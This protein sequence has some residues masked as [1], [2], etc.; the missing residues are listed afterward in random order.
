MNHIIANPKARKY[1]YGIVAAAIPLLVLGGF[2]TEDDVQ[3]WLTLAAAVL[4]FGSA[5]LAAPNTPDKSDKV[6]PQGTEQGMN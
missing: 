3:L 5:G 4:G 6:K 2:I 1:I